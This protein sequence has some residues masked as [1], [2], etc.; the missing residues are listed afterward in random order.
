MPL[1]DRGGAAVKK[2]MEQPHLQGTLKILAGVA[3]E[4][5]GTKAY[6]VR[7][8]SLQGRR[9]L[10]LRA[11]G[12]EHERGWGDSTTTAS[13]RGVHSKRERA[14]RRCPVAGPLGA[15]RG[16]VMDHRLELPREHLRLQQRSH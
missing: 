10:H 7:G 14:R 15:R 1:P 3:E 12:A 5:L 6:Y 9:R 16:G 11:L 8:R 13:V 4:L 2:I